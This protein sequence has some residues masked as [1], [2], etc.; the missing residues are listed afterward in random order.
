MRE[1]VVVYILGFIRI[2][3]GRPVGPITAVSGSSDASYEH[4]PYQSID[5]SVSQSVVF[6]SDNKVHIKK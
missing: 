5:Q 2:A 3:T 1:V 6:N 4:V